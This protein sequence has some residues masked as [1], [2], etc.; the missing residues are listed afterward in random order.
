MKKVK[1]KH[2][3][4]GWMLIIAIFSSQVVTNPINNILE[5]GGCSTLQSSHPSEEVP[6]LCWSWSTPSVVSK[7][8]SLASCRRLGGS[9]GEQIK[10]GALTHYQRGGLGL[11]MEGLEGG[12]GAEE[13]RKGRT[14]A[15]GQFDSKVKVL[16]LSCARIFCSFRTCDQCLKR[17]RLS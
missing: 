17:A 4:G 12:R 11:S 10:M 14:E 6:L 9:S 8:G 1:K 5:G 15:V 2:L 7:L 16:S 3:G 13:A